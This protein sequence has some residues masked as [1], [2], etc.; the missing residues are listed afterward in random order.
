MADQ[1]PVKMETMFL[2]YSTI[3]NQ[4]HTQFPV[5]DLDGFLGFL[6]KPPFKSWRNPSVYNL[7]RLTVVSRAAK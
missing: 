5:A 6:Q 2:Y 1:K 7:S 3:Q 4:S